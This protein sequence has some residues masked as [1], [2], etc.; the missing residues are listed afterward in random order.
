MADFDTLKLKITADASSADKSVKGLSN[1]L[2]DLQK[3][4]SN[5]S[6]GGLSKGLQQLAR[7]SQT[8]SSAAGQ[9][10]KLSK[11]FNLLAEASNTLS[12]VDDVSKNIQKIVSSLETAAHASGNFT[13]LREFTTSIDALRESV[14]SFDTNKLNRILRV[15]GSIKPIPRAKKD[16]NGKLVK[17]EKTEQDD[18][19]S[20]IA[21]PEAIQK[22][23]AAVNSFSDSLI[24]L[25]EAVSQLDLEK[26]RDVMK[27]IGMVSAPAAPAADASAIGA[28][29]GA[30]SKKSVNMMSI[31]KDTVRD[32]Q[33]S[34]SKLVRTIGTPLIMPFKR[35]GAE[36]GRA[37]AK[38]D[39]FASSFGRIAAY[40]LVRSIL[41]EFTKSATTGLQ[42]LAKYSAE[43]NA[44]L[45]QFSTGIL[46][47]QNSL[48]AALYPILSS[49][50]GL[51]NTLINV[52]VSALNVIN[53]FFS[54]LSGKFFY[55]RATRQTKDF[56]TATKGA[57]GAAKALKQELM[58][59]DEINSLSP[60]SGGG[61]GGGGVGALD[62]SKMFEPAPIDSWII[63][64]ANGDDWTKI[65]KTVA[66][67]LRK[68]LQS[69]N[70]TSIKQKSKSITS[71]LT[72]LFNGFIA[73]MPSDEI[74]AA[75]GNAI[76]T[77]IGFVNNLWY[78]TEWTV[79]GHKVG[80]ALMRT[81]STVDAKEVGRWF[82][83]KFNA[84]IRFLTGL[85]RTINWDSVSEWLGTALQSIIEN[86][87]LPKAAETICSL[88]VGAVKAI[89]GALTEDNITECCNAIVAALS[90]IVDSL[91]ELAGHLVNIGLKFA[92]G[93]ATAI[94][95][96]LNQHSLKEVCS[97]FV[98]AVGRFFSAIDVTPEFA[99]KGIT[100]T[101]LGL[102]GLGGVKL[103]ANTLKYKLIS[104]LSGT[105]GFSSAGATA[106]AGAGASA[107]VG[108]GTVLKWGVGIALAVDIVSS[109]VSDISAAVNGEIDWASVLSKYLFGAAIGG[110]V[111][112]VTG[113]AGAALLTADLVIKFNVSEVILNKLNEAG[114]I[115]SS[116]IQ[117]IKQIFQD[118]TN[119]EGKRRSFKDVVS[120]I[121]GGSNKQPLTNGSGAGRNGI[122]SSGKNYGGSSV[123]NGSGSGSSKVSVPTI[124]S[125]NLKNWESFRKTY[126]DIL[127]SVNGDKSKAAKLFIDVLNLSIKNMP[128]KKKLELGIEGASKAVLAVNTFLGVLSGVK[129]K[130]VNLELKSKISSSTTSFLEALKELAGGKLKTQ[131]GSL[132]NSKYKPTVE[133]YASGG[134]VTA[135][136][137]FIANE[138][139]AEMIGRIGSQPAVANQNQIGD[140]I[141]QYMDAY[142]ASS[143][144]GLTADQL[145]SAFITAIRVTG[146]GVVNI[147]G[148]TLKQSLVRE[149]QR[150][151]IPI[152]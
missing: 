76:S 145:T 135:G 48:G 122:G 98:N 133:K 132:I 115:V 96:Y 26:L 77:A 127:A 20:I 91:P 17:P 97:D 71:K 4:A 33:Q 147:D 24:K 116:G 50:V 19:S 95:N 41:S 8:V 18:L 22:N 38:M 23:V 43:A 59:F 49:I 75:I 16:E 10:S 12:N 112:A 109:A 79:L 101:I 142:G 148:R 65:G 54:A 92:G 13:A 130:S 138:N 121:F 52:V 90:T 61:G 146:L 104:L 81:V 106:A 107:G 150:S 27:Q 83:R 84:A 137:L 35:F 103:L 139:G 67:K 144:S 78:N 47:L 119:K 110:A 152:F 44:T 88:I 55:T 118:P 60:D 39:Q 126:S 2:R 93:M 11:S 51:F 151:G 123:K 15:S 72:T 68:G 70:W 129:D 28:A 63:D 6:F 21:S 69:I 140:A 102:A 40:R 85:S 80:E 87:N 82:A 64:A 56:T 141:F 86:V 7:D 74:G 117:G 36:I 25:Q 125:D 131:I 9:I 89:D 111:F 94:V 136:D 34:V 57:S 128:E 100:L 108:L 113:S 30:S 120:G 99:I 134:M 114:Q 105:A 42:N 14:E 37:K 62:Y 149:S 73:A 143:G 1:A 5:F 66:E 124:S 3:D 32:T 31:F 58:G 29:G 46:Y 45:S 53:A